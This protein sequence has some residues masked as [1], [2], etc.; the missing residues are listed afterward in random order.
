[1]VNIKFFEKRYKIYQNG[2]IKCLDGDSKSGLFLLQQIIEKIDITYGGSSD[3]FPVSIMAHFLSKK[4]GI[5]VISY[6]DYEME[7]APP[8]RIY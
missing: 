3:G 5:E 2:K 4:L 7:N 6:R 1:M 8:D